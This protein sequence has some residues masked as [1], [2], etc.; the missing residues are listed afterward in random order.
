MLAVSS[1]SPS[2]SSIMTMFENDIL[3]LNTKFVP[4]VSSHTQSADGGESGAPK[5]SVGDLT[6]SGTKTR[7]TNGNENRAK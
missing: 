7:D 5:K 1:S 4:L 2:A 3:E 6:D